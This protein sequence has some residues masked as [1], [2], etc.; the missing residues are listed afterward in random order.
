M[1]EFADVFT[2]IGL[3]PGECTIHLDLHTTLVVYP[4]RNIPLALHA[5]MKKELE[6]IEHSD[7]GTKVTKPW[8]WRNHTQA[9]SESV[10]TQER[11]SNT[12]IIIYQYLIATRTS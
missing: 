7:I 3:F 11:L 4:L 9:S 1:E 12:P 2:G 5:R 8:W 6:S 10:A